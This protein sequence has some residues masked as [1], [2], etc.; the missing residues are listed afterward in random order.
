MLI[1]TVNTG[2][3]YMYMLWMS[4]HVEIDD[5]QSYYQT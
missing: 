1:Y 4:F 5:N 3:F 2:I